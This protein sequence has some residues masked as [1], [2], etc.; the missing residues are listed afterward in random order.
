MQQ[1]EGLIHARGRANY[2]TAATYLKR[3]R[4][5]YQHLGEPGAWAA[6]IARLREDN[7]RL[8]ALKEELD[9]VGL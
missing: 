5:L 7:R 9:K 1:A 4:E 8:S 6:Y 3:V 2:A